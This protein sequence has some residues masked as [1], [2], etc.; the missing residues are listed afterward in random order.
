[1]NDGPG[2][3]AGLA[4]TLGDMSKEEFRRYGHELIDWV[5]DYFENIDQ[6]PVLSPIEPGLLKAQLPV[7]PPAK[8]ESMSAILADVDRLIVPAL[9]NWV[10][11]SFY[12]YFATS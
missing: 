11:P 6:L 9:T 2:E 3:A 7:T 5:A 1:M 12:A 4:P 10:H 8:G